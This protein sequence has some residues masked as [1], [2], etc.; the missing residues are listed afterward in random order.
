V[1]EQYQDVTT[2]QPAYADPWS[3]IH[4]AL[5]VFGYAGASVRLEAVP[6]CTAA[7]I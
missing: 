2:F 4:H 6:I 5:T 3:L 1:K 7:A